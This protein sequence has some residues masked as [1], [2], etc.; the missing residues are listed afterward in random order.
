MMADTDG[1]VPHQ[2]HD[3]TNAAAA[4]LG[5]TEETTVVGDV[6][7]TEAKLH[8]DEQELRRI[9]DLIPQTIVVLNPRK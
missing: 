5:A 1:A 3:G 6:K 8:Q 4:R 2:Q 7:R 9:I